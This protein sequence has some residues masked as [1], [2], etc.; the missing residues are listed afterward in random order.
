MGFCSGRK[1]PECFDIRFYKI[2]LRNH[3]F[4]HKIKI[5]SFF[6]RINYPDHT[7]SKFQ[8]LYNHPLH[9]YH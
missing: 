5:R 7:Q 6:E 4:I 2:M 8:A 9:E 1:T 3:I